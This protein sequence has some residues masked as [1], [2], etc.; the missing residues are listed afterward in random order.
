[1]KQLKMFRVVVLCTDIKVTNANEDGRRA[2][3]NSIDFEITINEVLQGTHWNNRDRWLDLP[4]SVF[5]KLALG[6][7]K[8]GANVADW[9]TLAEKL[10]LS[11]KHINQLLSLCRVHATLRPLEVLLL[12]W[13]RTQS[14]VPFNLSTLREVLLQIGRAD[15]IELLNSLN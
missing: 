13:S 15:L 1:M 12:H 7:E 14:P 4:H 9:K 11:F 6:L 3:E 2:Y 10:G 5:V 8:D